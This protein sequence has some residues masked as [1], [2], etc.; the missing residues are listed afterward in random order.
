VQ[1]R[2]IVKFEKWRELDL[3]YVDNWSLWLDLKILYR[4]PLEVLG[5]SSNSCLEWPK[6]WLKS[7][8]SIEQAELG[9]VSVW[10]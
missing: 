9:K 10:R 5:I 7:K 2:G 6:F 4:T 8:E 1:N 3:K